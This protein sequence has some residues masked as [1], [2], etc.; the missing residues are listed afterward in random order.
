VKKEWLAAQLAAG[1][2]YEAIAREVR[3]HPSTVSYWARRYGLRS[4]HVT[5]HAARGGIDRDVLIG[6]VDKGLSVRQI[7]RRLDRGTATVRHWLREYGLQTHRT[8]R[9]TTTDV[10]AGG[11]VVRACPRHGQTTFVRRGDG[12][13][14]RCLRCRSQAVTRH[15][16]KVKEI[17]VRE[18]GGACAMCGYDRHIGALAFHHVDR[19]DKRFG[20]S[21]MGLARSL[22]RARREAAKCVLLCANCHAEIEAGVQA[23]T[24]RVHDQPSGIARPA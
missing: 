14:W 18:A 11:V 15:R 4:T 23:L 8:R 3:R 12:Q 24:F 10:S 1:R 21:H 7:G 9:P 13:G 6:L 5:V 16:Q 22:E 20:L 19:V 17:L 2:S